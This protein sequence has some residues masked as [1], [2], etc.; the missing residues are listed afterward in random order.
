VNDESADERGDNGKQHF[1]AEGTHTGNLPKLGYRSKAA[2]PR[3]QTHAE[4]GMPHRRAV[5]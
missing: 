4:A 5:C 3:K 1:R 2:I